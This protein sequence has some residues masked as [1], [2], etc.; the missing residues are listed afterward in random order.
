M[1]SF[2]NVVIL[3]LILLGCTYE[4]KSPQAI[5]KFESTQTNL[6]KARLLFYE[7]AV[8]NNLLFTDGSRDFPSGMSTVILTA[9]RA[10]TLRLVLTGV[11]E[12][13]QINVAVYCYKKCKNWEKIYTEV[14]S[15]FSIHWKIIK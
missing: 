10:D 14:H 13:K 12:S 6:V 4:H 15:V 7:F 8:N 5:F 1:K 2:I 11:S 3:S 9:E